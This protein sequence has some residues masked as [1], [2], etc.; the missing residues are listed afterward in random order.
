LRRLHT[1]VAAVT[2]VTAQGY[3]SESSLIRDDGTP[4]SVAVSGVT[5]DFFQTLDLPMT[6]GRAFT[7]DD[8]VVMGRDAPLSP[9]VSDRAWTRLFNRDPTVVGRT[10]RLTDFRALVTVV[11]VASPALDL[12]MG[13]D[14]WMNFRMASD[15]QSHVLAAIVRL[16]P[17]ATIDQL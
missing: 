11:G 9:V 5:E 1:V 13:A 15:E 6:A 8:H 2:G 12:P 7:H 3:E 17:G 16:Q 4:V 14:F 10:L